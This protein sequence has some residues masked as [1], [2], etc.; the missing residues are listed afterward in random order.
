M[1]DSNSARRHYEAKEVGESRLDRTLR[2]QEERARHIEEW[3]KDQ[4]TKLL[5]QEALELSAAFNRGG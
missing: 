5:R 2:E 1:L 4:W 3:K